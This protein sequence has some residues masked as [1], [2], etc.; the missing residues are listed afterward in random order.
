[1]ASYTIDVRS[2]GNNTSSMSV[3]A[4]T[5]ISIYVP[6]NGADDNHKVA[7]EVSPDGGVSWI[8]TDAQV[9]GSG[10]ATVQCAAT[11]ARVCVVK[12]TSLESAL[13]VHLLAR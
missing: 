8:V 5:I 13:T 6:P 11:D 4:Y 3:S 12:S 2:A 7:V 9:S 10:M 1:M